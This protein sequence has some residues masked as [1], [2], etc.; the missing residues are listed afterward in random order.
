MLYVFNICTFHH[1][2]SSASWSEMR[3]G[4]SGEPVQDKVAV[5]PSRLCLVCR[6]DLLFRNDW[7]LSIA[8][9]IGH[10]LVIEHADHCFED[11]RKKLPLFDHKHSLK[12]S[13]VQRVRSV[14]YKWRTLWR[15]L[16][17]YIQKYVSQSFSITSLCFLPT[18]EELHVYLWPR[19]WWVEIDTQ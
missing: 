10:S 6:V 11:L 17:S 18:D 3:Q 5:A 9:F 19:S 2:M 15:P 8:S 16:S 1:D 14:P 7:T 12:T 4:T 13:Q